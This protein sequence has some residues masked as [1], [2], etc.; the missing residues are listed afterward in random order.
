MEIW[1][2]PLD[3]G[4]IRGENCRYKLFVAWRSGR[5]ESHGPRA[6]CSDAYLFPDFRPSPQ[7][8]VGG[9]LRSLVG[10]DQNRCRRGDST[11]RAFL[12]YSPGASEGRAID[13]LPKRAETKRWTADAEI[14][15]IGGDR[16][17]GSVFARP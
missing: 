8:R 4:A 2:P 3:I 11:A 1:E 14:D 12:L 7:Q 9:R 15:T 13:T 17:D 10:R 5:R 6:A 16:R